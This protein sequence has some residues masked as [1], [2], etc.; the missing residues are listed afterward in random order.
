MHVTYC[1]GSVFY[2]YFIKITAT[3]ECTSYSI[4][5]KTL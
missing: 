3:F 5:S 2:V 4:E 1:F